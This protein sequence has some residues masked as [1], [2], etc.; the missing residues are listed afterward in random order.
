[1]GGRAITGA[2]SDAWVGGA[3]AEALSSLS[4][5][6]VS[7]SGRR[8]PSSGIAGF[9]GSGAASGTIV[10]TGTDSADLFA[11]AGFAGSGSGGFDLNNEH[12]G[13]DARQSAA[14]LVVKNFSNVQTARIDWSIKASQAAAR[15]V[16]AGF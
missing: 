14:M 7:M 13:K 16:E 2:G 8:N 10:A 11:S 15:K 5:G 4:C 12:A 1:M 3:E 9:D 6:I